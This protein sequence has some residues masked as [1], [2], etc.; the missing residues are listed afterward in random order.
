MAQV[1]CGGC[2]TMVLGCRR[3]E[4]EED[5]KELEEESQ[6]LKPSSSVSARD[7][8]HLSNVSLVLL[9]LF[10]YWLFMWKGCSAWLKCTCLC[11]KSVFMYELGT[12]LIWLVLLF[13]GTLPPLKSAGPPLKHTVSPT[14]PGMEDVANAAPESEPLEFA[15]ADVSCL[16]KRVF[17][18]AQ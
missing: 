11:G 4:G 16:P 12:D 18:H 15:D 17:H 2:H 3:P 6:S 13:Q 14:V 1:G 5:R 9:P 10:L 7:R 8:R